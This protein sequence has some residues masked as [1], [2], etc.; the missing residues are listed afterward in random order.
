MINKYIK[1]I[2][3]FINYFTLACIIPIGYFAPLG[4]WLLL[5]LLS[6]TTLL[7]IFINYSKVNYKNLFI[8]SISILIIFIS[9]YWS[10]NPERTSEVIGPISGI[11]IAIFIVLNITQNNKILNI[12]NLIGIPLIITSLCI[13]S[14]MILNTEIRSNLAMLAGDAPTSRSANFGRG[15]IILLMIMPFSV[16][17]YINKGKILLALG[18][19]ILVSAIVILGPNHSA[20]I[21][22][23]I[24][25]L[26]SIIIYFLGPRSFLYFG[27][28]SII[29]IL[30][31]PIISSKILPP[32][33]S[34]EKN[35]YYNVPWQKTA[36]G[37]SII[38]RLLVW[39]YVANEIYKKPLLGYGTGTSRLIGQNIILNVPNT[40]QEIKGGIPLH[41]HNNFLEI[42][43]E[44][45]LLGIIIIN[46]LWMKIIKYGIQMRQDSYIIGTGVCSSIVTIFIIS[47][48]SFGVFQAW[49]MSSIALIFLI[50]LQFSKKEQKIN[51]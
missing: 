48:L 23:F 6:I 34:I 29:F 7:N 50:I 17:M 35:N 43:L 16:A 33:G 41:P 32:I 5:S 4:E 46:I 12:E 13:F 3:N 47:N 37:G 8:F 18:I 21:A 51:L 22:L 2:F 38:H 24:T 42:W 44:L 49:W 1:N 11:I 36:I 45:G 30:F 14:D 9:Y 19:V 25:I 40:N 39:E 27:I 20:K 31:L 28:I 10:I 26:S 15:I